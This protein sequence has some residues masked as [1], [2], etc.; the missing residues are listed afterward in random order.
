[1]ES[2][3]QFNEARMSAAVKLQRALER[4]RVKSDASRRRGEEVMAQARAEAEKKMKTPIKEGTTQI[5]GTDKLEIGVSE[6]ATKKK[7]DKEMKDQQNESWTFDTAAMAKQELADA[8][9]KKHRKRG[10]VANL[11]RKLGMKE[12]WDPEKFGSDGSGAGGA[13]AGD[14]SNKDKK[15]KNKPIE[16]A[17]KAEDDVPFDGPYTKGPK[18][19][20]FGNTVKPKNVAKFLAKR[21]MRKLE[22]KPVKE[23]AEQIDELSRDTLLSYAN[24]VSL[25]SQKHSKD[26]TK[27]SGQKASRSVTGYAKAHDRLEKP[28]KEESEQLE[29]RNKEN[30]TKRKMMD[31]SRGARF[32][33]NNPVPEAGAEHKTAQAHNKAIG[34][35]LR[36]EEQQMQE[37]VLDKVK[38]VGKKALETLGHGSDEQLRK[39]LQKKVGVPQT[40][41]KPKKLREFME[42]LKTKEVNVDKVNAAGDAPHDEK[43]EDVKKPAV[44]KESFTA[45]ELLVALKEGL[46]PGTPEHTAR[47]G[48]KYKQQQGGGAGVKK[49]TRYGGSAQKPDAEDDNDADDK[50]AKKKNK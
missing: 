4:E 43:F 26:P 32:K 23:E 49:G 13:G 8:K 40:G 18:K 28:V 24:K 37:G 38:A 33:L 15:K 34:R 50:P 46:W 44:K 27:R 2:F 17:K 31:A 1:M 9:N 22:G 29:E 30:A 3:K 12:G 16:E 6:I 45:D 39:D 14:I 48:D 21:A 19:D 47:F 20:E 35:A 10:K 36:N 5:N 11:L 7:T 41:E 42:S 25:D